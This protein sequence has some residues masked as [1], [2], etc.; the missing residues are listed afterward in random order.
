MPLF[1]FYSLLLVSHI[2]IVLVN[3]LY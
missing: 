2:T 1:S 3:N